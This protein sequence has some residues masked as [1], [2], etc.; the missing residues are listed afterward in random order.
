LQQNSKFINQSRLYSPSGERGVAA[1]TIREWQIDRTR[2]V[3]IPVMSDGSTGPA[4]E[5]HAL[6]EQF[7][8]ETSK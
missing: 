3:A 6:F 1:P 4:L 2:Y 8:L 5:L 7:L